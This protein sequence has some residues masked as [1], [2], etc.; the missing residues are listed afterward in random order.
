M[1]Q[2]IIRPLNILYIHIP[3][4]K[5][6]CYYCNFVS[7]ANRN[8]LIEDYITALKSEIQHVLANNPDVTLKSIYIGGGTPSI[9][10]AEHYNEILSLIS[11]FTNIADNAEITI[12]VNPGTITLEYLEKLKS[13]GINRLSIGIQSFNDKLLSLLNRQH[14]KEDALYAV[15]IGKQAGFDNIS[16]DLMYGLPEQ[17]LKIWEQTLD[18][19]CNANINHISAYGLKIEPDT[20][21]AKNLPPGLPEEELSADM[22]LQTKNMLL[23]C[24]FEHY[25]ISNFALKGYESRHNLSYWNNE[26]YFGF[27]LAAHGYVNGIRYSNTCNLN[28]YIRNSTTIALSHKLINQEIIEEGI[29]LGLRLTKGINIEKFRKEYNIDLLHDYQK[30]IS[31]Y[32]NYGFMEI[33]DGYIRL[34][35]KGILIS[36]VILADFL[37]L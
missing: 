24:G 4:C 35:D 20:R 6:K 19:A 28:E 29:F 18:Q 23:G 10:D 12:E 37:R 36:N 33:K 27:G 8:N 25:E 3:F 21:F 22:Y 16:I 17:T 31:K 32:A 9:I 30:I 5:D 26:E 15:K 7:F 11:S 13:F 34:S 14:N 1:P 2:S